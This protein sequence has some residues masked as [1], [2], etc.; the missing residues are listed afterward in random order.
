[1]TTGQQL[2]TVGLGQLTLTCFQ[3][4]TG[5]EAK[6]PVSSAHRIVQLAA[7][8]VD[9]PSSVAALRK[10]AA[11]RRELDAYERRQVA[12]AL[13]EG[14]TFASIARELGVS[15]QAVHRRFRSLAQAEAPATT[16][17]DVRRLLIYARDEALAAGAAAPAS[18]HVLLAA[19]RAPDLTAG[20]VLRGAGVTLE[21]ARAQLDPGAATRARF[22]REA[23]RTDLIALLRAPALIARE[24]GSRRIEVEHLLLGAIADDGGGASRMLRA[25]G[26]DVD[27]VR[28]AL[29]ASLEARTS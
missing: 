26:I 17:P 11:L 27:A 2:F 22:G 9:A 29:F 8:A 10:V 16:S 25:L 7:D 13:S 3:A 12:R 15:R 5:R 6:V 24:G 18:E 28:G 14:A 19:L 20:A 23:S 1:M 21:R 4:S